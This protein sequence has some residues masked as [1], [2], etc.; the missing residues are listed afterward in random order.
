MGH[1]IYRV[2]DPRA[3]VLE[4]AAAELRERGIAASRLDL[5]RAVERAAEAALA[6]RHPD[7]PLKAN[8]EFY[9]AVLLEAIGLPRGLFTP[10]FATARVVG[11][12]AHVDEQRRTG[13]LIRPAA[14]YV[15]PLPA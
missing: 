15:G 10:T 9:T 3:L 4:R 7:R 2:R 5:A 13:R 1:R 8:V 11:W 6:A 12:L 14:N